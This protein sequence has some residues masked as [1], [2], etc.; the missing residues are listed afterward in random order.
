MSRFYDSDDYD[1]N[2]APL[3][4]YYH[5]TAQALKSKRGLADLKRLLE[6]LDAMPEKVLIRDYLVD[7]DEDRPRV[8]ALGAF[9]AYERMKRG[10]TNDW[11]EAC[12]MVRVDYGTDVDGQNTDSVALYDTKTTLSLARYIAYQND[13][14]YYDPSTRKLIPSGHSLWQATRDKVVELI[15][16]AEAEQEARATFR[17]KPKAK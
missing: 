17:G 13:E 9:A 16:I 11:S 15:G 4:F 6:A 2:G 3:D 5:N 12:N 1:G 10:D 8:C 7:Y 14:G